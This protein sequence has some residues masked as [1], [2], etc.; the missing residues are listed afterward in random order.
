MSINMPPAHLPKGRECP[1]PPIT[2]ESSSSIWWTVLGG[3]GTSAWGG[4]GG[5][6]GGRF[7]TPLYET[8]LIFNSK[9]IFSGTEDFRMVEG[10]RVKSQWLH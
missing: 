3:R 6:G 2:N 4:G 10:V 9:S 1:T 8:L 7:P 5:G